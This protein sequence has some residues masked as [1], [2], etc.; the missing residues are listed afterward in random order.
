MHCEVVRQELDEQL[1]MHDGGISQAIEHS[2]EMEEKAV[3]AAMS[4]MYCLA[5]EEI[6]HIT[7]YKPL[8]ELIK[9][10]GLPFLETLHKG[11]NATCTSHM[12]VEEFLS[13]T[14]STVRKNFKI[15]LA[16]V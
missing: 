11:S 12:I 5:K 4:C 9:H 16:L 3:C 6:P 15:L 7:K 2:G 14:S 1:S 10:L 8:L 13:I